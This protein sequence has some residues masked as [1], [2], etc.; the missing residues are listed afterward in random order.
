MESYPFL[1]QFCHSH[2]Y[3]AVKFEIVFDLGIKR[4]GNVTP[5]INQ[6]KEETNEP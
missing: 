6:C 3:R 5:T 1:F 2:P 4:A